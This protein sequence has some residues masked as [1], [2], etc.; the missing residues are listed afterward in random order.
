MIAF[1]QQSVKSYAEKKNT[2]IISMFVTTG[3]IATGLTWLYVHFVGR[4]QA[5]TVL[6]WLPAVVFAALG[7]V[8]ILIARSA[9]DGWA[10]IA[11]AV[12][13]VFLLFSALVSVIVTIIL[14]NFA[15]PSFV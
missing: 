1:L 9:R 15:Y 4:H 3:L 2:A 10:A 11:Y 13:G 12:M 5:A 6:R 7:V 14:Y 8:L